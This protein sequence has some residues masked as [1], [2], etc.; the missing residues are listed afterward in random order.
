MRDYDYVDK[1]LCKYRHLGG[2]VTRDSGKYICAGYNMPCIVCYQVASGK[3]I[4]RKYD[5]VPKCYA[6]AVAQA[7]NDTYEPYY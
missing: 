5:K 2:Y 4:I 6:Q 1:I 3:Y 7:E